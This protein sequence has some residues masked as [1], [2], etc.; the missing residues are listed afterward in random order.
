MRDGGFDA[1]FLAVGAHIGKRAYIPA[2]EAARILDAVSLLRSMEGEE[3]AAARAP[4]RRL[5]RRQHRD[6]RGA[7]REA[8]RRRG[9]DRRLPPHARPHARPRLRG[10][11]GRGG[12]RPDEVALDDQARRRRASSCSRGWSSTR[13]ASRSRP[14]SSRSSR[15]TRS[16]SRSAR[17][18]TSRCSTACPGIEVEDGVVQ[19]GPNMMTGYPGI[20]AGGDMVPAE[21]TVTVGGRPRQEGRPAHR[22]AGCA[23]VGITRRRRSTS[24]P[25]STRSTPGTTRTRRARCSRSSSCARRRSTF[26]E[27]VGGPRRVERALRGAP[28]PVVR[29][30]LLVRQLLRRLPRQRRAQARTSR[31]TRYAIDYDFCKG[32]G[33]CVAE[34]PCGAIEMVPEE[35]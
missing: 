24:S 4:R 3:R 19:V 2:G 27:V 17:R 25:S 29:Q 26:E 11:G 32:C 1:V 10:R 21:R 15:P 14:A 13:P 20:F 9:G 7:H 5:R 18:P 30:L 6:G 12:G 22:R 8:P 23:D 28:L 16:C 34:C 35:V 33:I 31:A